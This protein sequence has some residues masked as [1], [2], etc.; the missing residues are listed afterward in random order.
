M[1]NTSLKSTLI[2]TVG[3]SQYREEDK[4]IT[5]NSLQLTFKRVYELILATLIL[6]FIGSW[7]FSLISIIIKLDSKGAVFFKQRRHGKDNIPFYC[8]KFRTMVSNDE[9]DTL[10]AK[11]GDHRITKF[12]AMLRRCSLDELPQLINVLKGDMSLVGP[13][14]HAIPMNEIFAKEIPGYMKRH[15]MKPGLTGLAQSKGVRGEILNYHDLKTRYRLDIFYIKNWN[16][17]LDFKI[18]IWTAYSLLFNNKKAY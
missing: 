7:L 12:G 10:Q 16:L 8:Y 4:S 1:N 17:I 2:T 18:I 15:S 5:A 3:K 11:R 13:R 9:A 6:I 14:P